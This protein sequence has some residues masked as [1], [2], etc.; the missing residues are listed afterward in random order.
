MLFRSCDDLNEVFSGD[1]F[2]I[3]TFKVIKNIFGIRN[4]VETGTYKGATSIYLSK[5]FEKVYSI[6]INED[7]Y[8]Y[9]SGKIGDKNINNIKLYHGSS[10]DLLES[11]IK[12]ELIDNS[13]LFYLDAHWYEPCPLLD[14]LES[15]SK[16]G[17]RPVI[18]IHDF[19]VPGSNLRHYGDRD[20]PFNF[21][22]IKDKLERIYGVD[23]YRYW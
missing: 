10:D 13:T 6:E 12:G 21:D 5:Y 23:G 8:K 20:R 14:E 17:L 15:I 3:Q 18:M 4:L 11:V 16:C 2:A 7:N 9:V 22:Y 19:Q 1:V